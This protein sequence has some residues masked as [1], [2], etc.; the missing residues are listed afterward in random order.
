[1]IR[2]WGRPVYCSVFRFQLEGIAPAAVWPQLADVGNQCRLWRRRNYVNEER[3]V[4]R[5]A[6]TGHSVVGA[7]LIVIL[8]LRAGDVDTILARLDSDNRE[9]T[10]LIGLNLRDLTSAFPLLQVPGGMLHTPRVFDLT[11]LEERGVGPSLDRYRGAWHS[12][13]T[14]FFI[15]TVSHQGDSVAAD[16]CS[17][18]PS[19]RSRRKSPDHDHTARIECLRE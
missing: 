7:A 19:D 11:F 5:I 9:V 14:T 8:W 15:V 18:Q 1:M 17:R 12:D 10:R 3:S 13:R 16:D 2:H 6:Y 4:Q